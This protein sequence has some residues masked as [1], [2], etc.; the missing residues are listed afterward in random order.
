MVILSVIIPTYNSEKTIQRCLNSIIYQNFQNFEICI[1]D[2]AS[3]DQTVSKVS[4][5]RSNFKNI[6]I[7]SEPDQGV[8]DAMNKGIDI[9]Q[10][11]WLYF[12]GSDDEVFDKDVF[13]DIFNISLPKRCG[14]IY[15]NAYVHDDTLWAKAGQVYDGL[16]DIRKILSRNICHQAIFY[17]KE[18]FQRFGKYKLQYSVCAD[19]E[20]N[21]RLFPKTEAI[22]L[23]RI[24]AKFYGGGLSTTANDDL[25]GRDLKALKKQALRAYHLRRITSFFRF[26]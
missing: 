3:L 2:G 13:L 24:I 6:K 7:V 12:L 20:L 21:I 22:Y 17:K 14:M 8:Y 23:D 19:W 9:A 16:F 5:F 1:I 10:G 18:L 25:I 26:A 15:G 4:N 11:D